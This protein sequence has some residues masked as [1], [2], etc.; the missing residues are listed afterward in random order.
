MPTYVFKG[1]NGK[2]Y[3]VSGDGSAEE[4]FAALQKQVPDIEVAVN[5]EK[6]AGKG[7][8]ALK[9]FASY[10]TGVARGGIATGM[11]PMDLANLAKQYLKPD[12]PKNMGSEEALAEANK[13][14]YQPEDRWERNAAAIGSGQVAGLSGNPIVGAMSALGGFLGNELTEIPG[15]VTGTNWVDRGIG[16]VGVPAAQIAAQSSLPLLGW[17]LHAMGAGKF[18]HFATTAIE[19][20]RGQL[21]KHLAADKPARVK[22]ATHDELYNQP[23]YSPQEILDM[24]KRP[25]EN[26]DQIKRLAELALKREWGTG[27]TYAEGLSNLGDIANS[28]ITTILKALLL[29]PEIQQQANK[30]TL[31]Q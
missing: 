29:S 26:P 25:N 20:M 5:Q 12:M 9:T 1:P 22:N 18:G 21:P 3:Q 24:S 7:E 17:G 6:M 30:P 2:S 10:G 28:K 14:L 15:G 13:H 27:G 19:K 31:G 8:G 23:A 11:L 16:T 4:A